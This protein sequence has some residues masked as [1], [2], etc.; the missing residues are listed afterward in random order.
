MDN[1]SFYG[2]TVII[3]MLIPNVIYA[4]LTRGQEKESISVP[5]IIENIG[6]FGTMV[7]MV[8]TF[9]FTAIEN[10]PRKKLSVWIICITVLLEVYFVFW[11]I[12]YLKEKLFYIPLSTIPCAVFIF[13]GVLTVNIPLICFAA[14]FSV[15]HIRDNIKKMQNHKKI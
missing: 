10:L 9:G 11:L 12:Y 13:T 1:L 4:L 14:V 8:Y 5:A 2:L 6:R 7:T 3:L 15:F